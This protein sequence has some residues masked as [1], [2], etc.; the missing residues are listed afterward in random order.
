MKFPKHKAGLT[1]TH[2]E[3]LNYYETFEE[4]L[5]ADMRKYES[6]VWVSIAER[7]KAIDTNE[8][9]E[10]HWYPD[11]PIGACMMQAS[12]LTALLEWIENESDFDEFS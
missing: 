10:L 12:S 7:K 9:W 3:H 1:L 5:L 11:T 2:N 8:V 4:H 6:I